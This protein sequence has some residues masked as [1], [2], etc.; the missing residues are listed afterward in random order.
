MSFKTLI[1]GA[2]MA[3]CLAAGAGG[4]RRPAP[5]PRNPLLAPWTGPYGGVPPFD[6]AK[7]EHFEA[8][9]RGR[10]GRAARRDR[11]HRGQPRAAPTFENT[12]AAL[13]RAGRTLNRVETV[14]GVYSSTLNDEAV[15]AVEREM[16]PKL[17]AFQRP[18][19][20]ERE[21]VRAHRGRVRGAREVG[22]HARAAAAHLALLHELRPRR[23]EARR[24]RP[25]SSSPRSTSSWR[26]SSRSSARTCSPTRTTA[27]SSSRARP[28]S[29]GCPTSVRAGAAQAAEAR[30]T[31]GQVGH[32]QHAL[33]RRAVPH[34]LRPPRPARE[35]LAHVR[36]PRRQRRRHRQQRRSSP[37]SCSCAPS[38]PS[39]SATRR[40][41]TGA[42]R[43]PWRR[44]PS[45]PW[46]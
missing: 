37:R 27:S 18:D 10:H 38:A 6:Q 31:E 9:A 4:C 8:R 41:R 24:R 46:S 25:R 15:Q 21:A 13:E 26:R 20:A 35:G 44:R 36:Q 16:A 17:A 34:L 33:E 32:R 1:A 22:P 14:Y 39:C 45:A 30:G 12:I 3:A 7:V 19:H 43:T 23:R 28:I 40:T 29:P 42:S 11:P 5:R 2:G